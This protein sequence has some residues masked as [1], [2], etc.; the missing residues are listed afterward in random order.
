[1]GLQRGN[2]VFPRQIVGGLFNHVG[3]PERPVRGMS[4]LLNQRAARVTVHGLD[5]YFLTK[6]ISYSES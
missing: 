3:L 6:M 5:A 2:D 1:M 4:A